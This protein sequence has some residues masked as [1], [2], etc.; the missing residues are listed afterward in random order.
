M[1]QCQSRIRGT[2]NEEVGK[3]GG[4]AAE[5]AP[6]EEDLGTEV[7]VTFV[8]TDQV[9]GNDGNDLCESVSTSD[10]PGIQGNLTYAVP[11]P[12]G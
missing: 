8:G 11:E 1:E 5:G 2:Y 9:G 10:H 3:G 12:I 4:E 6:E 7:R